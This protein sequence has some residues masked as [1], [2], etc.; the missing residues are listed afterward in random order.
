MF[1]AT[2]LLTSGFRPRGL[3]QNGIAIGVL[4][5]TVL[6]EYWS[7]SVKLDT[8]WQACLQDVVLLV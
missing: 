8:F 2:P 1:T 7:T 4:G 3:I 5:H 6:V